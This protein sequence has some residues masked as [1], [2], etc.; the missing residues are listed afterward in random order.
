LD[1]F[2]I[3]QENGQLKPTGQSERVGAPVSVLFVPAE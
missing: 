2:T 1:L 3:D